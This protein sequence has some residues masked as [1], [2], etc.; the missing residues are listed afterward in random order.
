MKNADSGVDE[1]EE[2]GG[3]ATS[4][5]VEEEAEAAVTTDQGRKIGKKSHWL[6]RKPRNR[7]EL[8]VTVSRTGS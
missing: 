6:G 7:D 8:N 3:E 1:V 4:V 2:A 5:V